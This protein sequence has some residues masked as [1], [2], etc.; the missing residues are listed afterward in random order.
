MNELKP[1]RI[2]LA[3]ACSKLFESCGTYNNNNESNKDDENDDSDDENELILNTE[4]ALD[5]DEGRLDE[6]RKFI[7]ESYS[8]LWKKNFTDLIPLGIFMKDSIDDIVQKTCVNSTV[9]AWQCIVTKWTGYFITLIA[10]GIYVIVEVGH[11]E[12]PRSF[13]TCSTFL[14]GLDL[15]NAYQMAYKRSSKEV[16]S[17]INENKEDLENLADSLTAELRTWNRPTLGTPLF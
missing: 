16:L 3:K 12:L 5:N 17:V 6:L 14:N 15:L 9:F 11:V 13:E 8:K 1:K 7:I 10:P 4:I 2:V